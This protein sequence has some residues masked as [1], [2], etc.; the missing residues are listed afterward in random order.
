ML[1]LNTTCIIPLPLTVL[2]LT[3]RCEC[4]AKLSAVL[5]NF[6]LYAA[7][8]SACALLQGYNHEYRMHSWLR[9]RKGRCEAR[10]NMIDMHVDLICCQTSMSELSDMHSTSHVLAHMH[11][12]QGSERLMLANM[13]HSHFLHPLLCVDMLPDHLPQHPPTRSSKRKS[14]VHGDQQRADRT[15][16]TASTITA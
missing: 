13:L 12:K 14:K 4:Y 8:A 11:T 7:V 15:K 10:I 1:D 2:L 9:A 16:P 6:N 3:I 5:T